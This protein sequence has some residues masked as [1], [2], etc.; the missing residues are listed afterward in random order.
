LVASDEGLI[1]RG[2]GKPI[3]IRWSDASVDA[4]ERVDGA[5][6]IR[7]END[8]EVVV[9]EHMVGAKALESYGS[10]RPSRTSSGSDVTTW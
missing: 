5:V 6:V 9:S 8:Q 1:Q 4:I 7:G 10:Q 2:F 3:H